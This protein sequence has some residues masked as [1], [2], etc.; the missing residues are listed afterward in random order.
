MA[1]GESVAAAVLG[2]V[3]SVLAGSAGISAAPT[4]GLARQGSPSAEWQWPLAP[5]PE[6]ER[7]FDP[8]DRPWLPGH[9]GVDLQATAGQPVLAPTSGQV[10]FSG[11]LA[12]RGVVVVT[13]PNGL[14]STFE[15]VEAGLAVGQRVVPGQPVARVSSGAGHCAPARCLHWGVLRVRTYLDP[16]SLLAHR[17]VVLLPLN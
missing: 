2:T 16:L 1:I 11:P 14:R 9:R 10:T 3:L 17:P 15:P 6:V 12:G 8:P 4:P 5:Q 13:H 7:G